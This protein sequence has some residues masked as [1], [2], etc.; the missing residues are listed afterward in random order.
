MAISTN[1]KWRSLFPLILPRTLWLF[2]KTKIRPYIILFV[3]ALNLKNHISG[4]SAWI[5]VSSLLSF[6]WEVNER[7]RSHMW[8]HMAVKI[9]HN[10]FSGTKL[11]TLQKDWIFGRVAC[12]LNNSVIELYSNSWSINYIQDLAPYSSWLPLH[13]K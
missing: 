5:F 2:C 8:K 6:H 10:L 7:G 13:Q 1:Y 4:K 9:R 3:R 12:A 11:R